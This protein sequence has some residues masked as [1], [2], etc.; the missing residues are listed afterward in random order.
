[1]THLSSDF[2]L[3]SVGHILTNVPL[4]ATNSIQLIIFLIVIISNSDTIFQGFA[5]F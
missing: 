4:I 1:M 5:K 2:N 3:T